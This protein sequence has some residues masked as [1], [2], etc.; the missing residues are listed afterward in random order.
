MVSVVRY[1]SSEL[2]DVLFDSVG[3]EDLSRGFFSFSTFENSLI[4]K[5]SV[6]AI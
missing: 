1:L 5:H 3:I 6:T 2:V 4:K